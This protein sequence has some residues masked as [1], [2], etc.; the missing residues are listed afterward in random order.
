MRSRLRVLRAKALHTLDGLADMKLADCSLYET[1][2]DVLYTPS[3]TYIGE[4]CIL[5]CRAP[6]GGGLL[7]L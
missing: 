7:S 6:Y 3:G 4:A 1:P 5:S 2:R